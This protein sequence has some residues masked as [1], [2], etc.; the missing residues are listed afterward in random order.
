[1]YET[2]VFRTPAAA[3]L[4][5]ATSSVFVVEIARH[6][7]QGGELS[8]ILGM[9]AALTVLLGAIAFGAVRLILGPGPRPTDDED[10]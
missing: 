9:S 2:A 7:I 8:E 5:V 3:L 1:M 4:T 10:D 6:L